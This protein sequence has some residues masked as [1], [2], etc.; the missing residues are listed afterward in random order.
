[1]IIN[2]VK[3]TV[4]E[5]E[6]DREKKFPRMVSEDVWEGVVWTETEMMSREWAMRS[7]KGGSRQRASPLSFPGLIYPRFWCQGQNSAALWMD[8]LAGCAWTWMVVHMFDRAI[9]VQA[10]EE[11][12]SGF[13]K[14]HFIK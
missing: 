2:V 6:N 5:L 4:N 13:E 1:M 11:H 9:G 3:K 14:N 12:N 7:E 10:V 8:A